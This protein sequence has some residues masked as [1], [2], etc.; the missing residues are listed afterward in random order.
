MQ[1][2]GTIKKVGLSTGSAACF[3]NAV[4]KLYSDQPVS[5][6]QLKDL[7]YLIIHAIKKL[8]LT[9][10]EKMMYIFSFNLK[11]HQAFV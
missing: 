5:N 8:F 1:I 10:T 4:Q 2:F 9:I 7:N 11:T 3:E 6:F